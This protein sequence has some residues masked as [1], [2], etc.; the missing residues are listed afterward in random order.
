MRAFFYATTVAILLNPFNARAD[1]TTKKNMDDEGYKLAST[2]K[3][4]Q[5]E[6]TKS[7]NV[8]LQKGKCTTLGIEFSKSVQW[9]EA[10]KT[11]KIVVV[12]RQGGSSSTYAYLDFN[13]PDDHFVSLGC[14]RSATKT[15]VLNLEL[16][17]VEGEEKYKIGKGDLITKIY[18]KPAEALRQASKEDIAAEERSM[19]QFKESNR[20]KACMEC[21]ER[22]P[23]KDDD[24]KHCVGSYGV[25]PADCY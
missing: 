13:K 9:T 4:L 3:S 10:V 20:K 24:F 21:A 1:T 12:E 18:T 11:K 6:Q 7:L 25:A 2:S 16:Y 14:E 23:A 15:K 17:G 5:L 8:E 19:Q 22:F